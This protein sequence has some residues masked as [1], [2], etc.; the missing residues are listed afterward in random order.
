MFETEIAAGMEWLDRQDSRNP[1][2]DPW[3]SPSRI[4]TERL[5]LKRPSKCVIG[6]TQPNGDDYSSLEYAAGTEWMVD[7]GFTLPD[8]PWP[9][10]A[11]VDRS[12]IWATLTAEW[13]QAIHLRRNPA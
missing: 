5:D 10:Y 8:Q 12:Q 4:D 2:L 9:E 3:Y 6:Q 7:K 1:G 13:R 11:Y